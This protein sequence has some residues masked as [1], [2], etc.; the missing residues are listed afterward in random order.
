MKA[1]V[2]EGLNKPLIEREVEKPV[3]NSGEVLVKIN[4]SSFNRRDLWIQKG[5]Y[6]GIKYPII[7][8]S[9]GAGLVEELGQDVDNKWNGMKVIINPSSHWGD[10]Y[11]AQSKDF[12][13]LGLPDNGT[14]AEYVKVPVDNLYPLP[15]HLSYAEAASLPLAGVTAFRALFKRAGAM[16]GEK[17]LISGVGGGVALFAMQFAVAEGAEVYVTSG[18]PEKIEKAKFL[19]AYGGANYRNSNWVD[20]LKGQAGGFDVIIDSAGG[21]GFKQLIELANPGGRIALYGATNGNV[22]ELDPRRIY[23][24]QLSILGSTMGTKADFESM[25]DFVQKHQLLPVVDKVFGFNEANDALERISKSE[26]FGKI[27]LSQES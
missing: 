27:I 23:W 6:A 5:L 18:N 15:G 11:R 17:V 10:D 9:D 22:P 1:L 3:L 2:L 4:A 8:G 16:K 7:L 25:I 14:F 24:K 13:I 12:R 20:D 26:Q 21:P 19:G